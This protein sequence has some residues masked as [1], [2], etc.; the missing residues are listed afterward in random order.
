LLTALLKKGLPI[1]QFSEDTQ[2]LEE[3]FMRATQ[4]IVS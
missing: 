4:G 2:N 3:V 1:V